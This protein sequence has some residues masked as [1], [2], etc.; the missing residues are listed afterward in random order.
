MPGAE[1]QQLRH[2]ALLAWAVSASCFQSAWALTAGFIPA[3]LQGLGADVIATGFLLGLPPLAS[4]AQLAF[5]AWG[6][7]RHQRGASRVGILLLGA[8]VFSGAALVMASASGLLL[9]TTAF[10]LLW[11]GTAAY[12]SNYL[13]LLSDAIPTRQRAPA[14]SLA[15]MLRSALTL[16]YFGGL[17][18]LAGSTINST[19]YLVAAALVPLA[20]LY[21]AT[22]FL[23][24]VKQVTA[25]STQDPVPVPAK[26][27]SAGPL[28]RSFFLAHFVWMFSL[29]ALVAFFQLFL[30]HDILQQP[31]SPQAAATAT[32]VMGIVPCAAILW[33]PVVRYLAGRIGLAHALFV[34]LLCHAAAS[35]LALPARTVP[36]LVPA[37]I[38]AGF[39]FVAL[40]IL[41]ITL[42]SH[43]QPPHRAAYFAG[44]LAVCNAMAHATACVVLGLI[45]DASGSYRSMFVVSAITALMAL[46]LMIPFLKLRFGETTS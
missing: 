40:I 7:R 44:M 14:M 18:F 39:S 3:R 1:R 4:L 19:P 34:A 32:M 36:A 6:D 31:D 20:F 22:G 26:E 33:A 35:G 28:I 38:L 15:A 5:G 43:I 25:D 27:A 21:T 16:L 9:F 30:I 10:V 11:I 29:S 13:G 37:G 23:R 12:E 24:P 17:P 41:P 8:L 2:R 46:A 45:I 42:L